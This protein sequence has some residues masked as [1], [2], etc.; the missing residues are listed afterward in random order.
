MTL[1][2]TQRRRESLTPALVAA[3]ALHI[4]VF[5][6]ALWAGRTSYVPAGTA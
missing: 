5:A 2:A 1:T 3:A 6:L 4:G